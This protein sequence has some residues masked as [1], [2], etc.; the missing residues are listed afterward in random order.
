MFTVAD[1]VLFCQTYKIKRNGATRKEDIQAI[2]KK[3]FDTFSQQCRALLLEDDPVVI[4]NMLQTHKFTIGELRKYGEFHNIKMPATV[5][6]SSSLINI[7]LKKLDTFNIVTLATSTHKNSKNIEDCYEPDTRTCSY[8]PYKDKS[9]GKVSIGWK[10]YVDSNRSI[11]FP[12]DDTLLICKEHLLELRQKLYRCSATLLLFK[13]DVNGNV[14]YSYARTE[15]LSHLYDPVTQISQTFGQ[16]LE[17]EVSTIFIDKCTI[18]ILAIELDAT[19]NRSDVSV[20]TFSNIDYRNGCFCNSRQ[21]NICSICHVLSTCLKVNSTTRNNLLDVIIRDRDD[22]RCDVYNNSMERTRIYSGFPGYIWTS[23]TQYP[24]MLNIKQPHPAALCTIQAH[25]TRMSIPIDILNILQPTDFAAFGYSE[26]RQQLCAVFGRKMRIIPRGTLLFHSS[27]DSFDKYGSDTF[28]A[29][30]P[31]LNLQMFPDTPVSVGIAHRDIHLFDFASYEATSI[32]GKE[33]ARIVL[34]KGTWIRHHRCRETIESYIHK[35]TE[36]YESNIETIEDVR[37]FE[38]NRKRLHTGY[39]KIIPTSTESRSLSSFVSSLSTHYDG[40]SGIDRLDTISTD[41]VR[42]KRCRAYQELLI[43]KPSPIWTESKYNDTTTFAHGIEIVLSN[44]NSIWKVPSDMREYSVTD[45]LTCIEATKRLLYG[46]LEVYSKEHDKIHEQQAEMR[47]IQEN[48][49]I[50]QSKIA[51][52]VYNDIQFVPGLGLTEKE[53]RQINTDFYES[54]KQSL[55]NEYEK[56][57]FQQWKHPY[58]Q[59]SLS[60][61]LLRLALKHVHTMFDE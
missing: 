3:F 45:D 51:S 56:L 6:N 48:M 14:Y 40:W 18:Y 26:L 47:Q 21:T 50:V 57:Q 61:E 35:R 9:C 58:N 7:I 49:N 25:H 31:S 12:R 24:F 55:E 44:T 59:L 27:K 60:M 46:L 37:E 52:H 39:A 16:D 2:V 10:A 29:L 36:T 30:H 19:V 53:Q 13:V 1:L 23:D 28:F 33:I 20:E 4:R 22:V 32:F 43:R 42:L 34:G 15:W 17:F 38:N 11:S 8:K 41:D 5:K 54:K